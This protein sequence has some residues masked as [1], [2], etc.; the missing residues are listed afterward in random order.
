MSVSFGG[1]NSN[2]VTFKTPVSIESGNAVKISE[3]NTVVPCEDGDVFCGFAVDGENGYPWV[4]W[5]PEIGPITGNTTYEATFENPVEVAEIA[6]DWDTILANIDNGTYASVYKVGN[7]KPLDLGSEGTINM[8]IA[9]FDTDDLADGTGKAPVTFIAMEL[10]KTSHQMNPSVVSNADGTYQDAT[11]GVGGWEKCEMRPY[12][13]NTIK[14]KIPTNV[15]SRIRPVSKTHY[16][17]DTDG[18]VFTQATTDAVWM[19][20]KAEIYANTGAYSLIYKFGSSATTVVKRKAGATSASVWWLRS[21]EN[22]FGFDKISKVGDTGG[23][24]AS[25]NTYAVCLG[26]CIGKSK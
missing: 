5:K 24:L 21:T 4:G 3:S 16:A 23:S 15:A 6:D 20:S 1:F 26:F 14:P 19:P 2:A 12:L 18:T 11:G 13:V 17:V 8:Q 22:R 10:L 25:D 7:Y 9:A